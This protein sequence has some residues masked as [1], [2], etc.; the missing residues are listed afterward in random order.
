MTLQKTPITPKYK[1]ENGLT[2]IDI[3][4]INLPFEV[5]EKSIVNI[6]PGQFGGNHQ[7]PRIEAFIGLSPDLE[8]IYLDENNKKVS[9]KMFEN[10]QYYLII[11]PTN[12]PHAIT[13]KSKNNFAT[14]FEFASDEQHNIK[15]IN[16]L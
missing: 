11:M 3:D 16:I 15:K 12:L 14:L 8:L 1:K 5:K 6:P 7:H 10:N 9:V 13:N 2:V 4:K